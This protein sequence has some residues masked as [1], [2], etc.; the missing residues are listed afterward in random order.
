VAFD[1]KGPVIDD[2]FVLDNDVAGVPL[3]T[4]QRPMRH[5]VTL[6]HPRTGLQLEVT[7]TEPS[8]QFYTG[9]NID[10]PQIITASGQVVPAIKPR[11][12]IAIEPNRYVNAVNRPEWR[13]LV[14]LKKG[15]TWGSK[16]R[17][18]VWRD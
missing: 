3:D 17:F 11:A 1:A 15:E 5:A 9:D 10:I 4:R 16:S 14:L 2:C 18:R 13:S 12:G 7:T 6:K 8:F